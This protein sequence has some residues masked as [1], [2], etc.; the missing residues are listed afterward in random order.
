MSGDQAPSRRCGTDT[1]DGENSMR[2]VRPTL[3]GAARFSGSSRGRPAGAF[4][5]VPLLAA[6]T[7]GAKALFAEEREP[8][9]SDKPPEEPEDLD[10]Q[11]P[12][13]H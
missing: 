5:A 7:S 4:V 1:L 9:R 10:T 2:R 11:Q 6:F 12:V 3:A 8:P 13:H